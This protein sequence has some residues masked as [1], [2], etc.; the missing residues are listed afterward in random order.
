M[1]RSQELPPN[2]SLHRTFDPLPTFAAAKAG[3]A[4]NA[5]ELRRYTY[6]VK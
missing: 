2:K 6:K 3:I 5:G 1:S 4:S